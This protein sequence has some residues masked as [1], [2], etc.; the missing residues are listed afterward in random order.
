MSS[1]GK[2]FGA[3]LLE[4]VLVIVTLVIGWL[5][6]AIIL[7]QKGQSP[8]KSILKMRVLKIDQNRAANIGEMAMRELVGKWLLSIVPFWALINGVVLLV[9]EKSQAVWDKIAGTTVI[10]DPDDSWA[11]AA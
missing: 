8:A 1:K 11:P 4:V 10:D 2:R 5:V 3:F 9:D 6:W 7:W